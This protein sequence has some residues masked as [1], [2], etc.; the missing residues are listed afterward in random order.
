MSF[1]KY[2]LDANGNPVLCDDLF[3]WA[4][5]FETSGESRVVQKTIVADG[6]QVSTIFLGIDHNWSRRGPPM[7]Y[8]T[9]VFGGPIEGDCLRAAKRTTALKNHAAMIAK[10]R[11]A[12][13]HA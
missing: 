1:R 2:I 7:I 9:R 3:T 8:E 12:L 6:V 10:T 13:E 11:E 5:W 4:E